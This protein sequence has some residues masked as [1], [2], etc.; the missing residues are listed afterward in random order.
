AQQ[1]EKVKAVADQIAT[2]T[3]PDDKKPRL[4]A[5]LSV[6]ETK[7]TELSNLVK[8][9]EAQYQKA[10]VSLVNEEKKNALK[11]EALALDNHEQAETLSKKIDAENE[12]VLL[13]ELIALV[14]AYPQDEPI[15]YANAAP[16]AKAALQK[17]LEAAMALTATEPVVKIEDLKAAKDKLTKAFA[18]VERA[19]V[20]EYVRNKYNEEIASHNFDETV[21]E[22]LKEKINNTN[23]PALENLIEEHG[24][25]RGISE[26]IKFVN[27]L[28]NI[29]GAA[30]DK[31][32]RALLDNYNLPTKQNDL[33]TL[34]N[35]QNTTIDNIES[36]K[37]IP[38][39]VKTQLKG[40]T[41]VAKSVN[42]D[43][44]KVN[45]DALSI[46]RSADKIS[47]SLIPEE[48]RKRFYDRI[49]TNLL[50]NNSLENLVASVDD[51]IVDLNN[52]IVSP[53][54]N[55]ELK[56]ILLNVNN[57]KDV[58]DF[59]KLLDSENEKV[60][61]DKVI[62]EAD[63]FLSDGE[64]DSNFSNIPQI[65]NLKSVLTESKQAT[66]ENP[67][68]SAK[69]LKAQKEKLIEALN[70]AKMA[71]AIKLVRDK[72]KALI[73]NESSLSAPLK[74][75]LLDKIKPQNAPG[76]AELANS[77]ILLNQIINN[78]KEVKN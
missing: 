11:E 47:D 35:K 9:I 72:L 50:N 23:S 27:N 14:K 7:N 39:D 17:E 64:F 55:L 65:Q 75:R 28:E 30:E 46:K 13:N 40:L 6:N 66:F 61:L 56:A 59:A 44:D 73:N 4:A 52:S 16:E 41:L 31:V 78:I 3:I 2:S 32:E 37:N 60:R 10:W 63:E 12:R 33:I 29:T 36:Y 49:S 67:I 62:K 76:L 22:A 51:K 20:T 15:V 48:N 43:V 5:K 42:P 18:G 45:A 19:A 70:N 34:A 53:E 69:D 24:K 74:E 1:I 77:E 8:D 54:K 38:E 21:T 71:S 57:E 68:K 25:I 26:K 58:E